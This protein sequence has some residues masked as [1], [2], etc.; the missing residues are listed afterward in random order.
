MLVD[1]VPASILVVNV[2][3]ISTWMQQLECTG[4]VDCKDQFD[5]IKPDT[6]IQELTEA[7]KYL[8]HAK[9]WG[10]NKIVWSI[11]WDFNKLDRVG[12]TSSAAFWHLLHKDLVRLVT[13][14]LSE[15]NHVWSAGT[16]W[17]RT[18][19]IPMGGSFSTHNALICTVS[20]N[21]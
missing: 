20:G 6:S 13:F 10:S 19:A 9:S 21:A 2:S 7:S 16:L 18:H 15:E 1:T 3:D 5:K 17:Q 14:S 4:E 8:Y 11:H 12:K